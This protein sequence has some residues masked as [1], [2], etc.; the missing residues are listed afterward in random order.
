[1][2][3]NV[4]I[5]ANVDCF[6]AVWVDDPPPII[7]TVADESDMDHLF[8]LAKDGVIALAFEQEA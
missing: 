5:A 3:Y 2:K 4:K 1:M 6:S 8:A 7:E